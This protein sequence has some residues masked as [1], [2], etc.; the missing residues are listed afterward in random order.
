MSDDI[1]WIKD[2][3]EIGAVAAAYAHAADAISR[4]DVEEGR[5]LIKTCFAE[6]AVFDAFMPNQDLSTPPAFS[7]HGP[8]AWVDAG[9]K[10]FAAM[11]YKATQHHMG[12]IQ[13][14]VDGDTATME[15]CLTGPHIIDSD[16]AIDFI[17][18]TYTD[19]LART[20]E[21]W[22]IKHRRLRSTG[23][24][25][26]ESPAREKAAASF[27]EMSPPKTEEGAA[28][29]AT[30]HPSPRAA[31][32]GGGVEESSLNDRKEIE[33]LATAYASA[34]DA[35]TRGDVEEARQILKA[36]FTDKTLFESYLPSSD[37][38]GPPDWRVV[39]P[40]AWIEAVAAVRYTDAQHHVGNVLIDVRGDTAAMWSCMTA[41]LI[42]ERERSIDLFTGSYTDRLER[43]PSGFRI[44]HRRVLGTSFLRLTSPPSGALERPIEAAAVRE[45]KGQAPLAVDPRPADDP[46]ALRA[47]M[48]IEAVAVAYAYAADALGRGDVEQGR[49]IIK[50]CFTDDAVFEAFGPGADPGAPPLFSTTGPD[51]W[52]DRVYAGLRDAGCTVTQHHIGNIEVHRRGDAAT[53]RCCLTATHGTGSSSIGLST[54]SYSDDMVRTAEGWRI[55]RRRLQIKSGLHLQ[56]SI[57][58]AAEAAFDTITRA[59]PQPPPDD[60]L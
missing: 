39:G 7:F 45:P 6:D 29:A 32:A 52:V 42:R 60:P 59:I 24:L 8:D 40:D 57:R 10:T 27:A 47:Q 30:P 20:P 3:I 15:C 16:R 26:L 4:G 19:R 49:A 23:L 38:S 34:A 18:G 13:V 28:A 22:R 1:R 41:T 37:R 2:Q 43:T 54:G 11:S 48:E 58:D 55:A 44:L 51:A 36:C 35:A 12:N 46:S 14:R 9:L 50:D 31:R 33:A 17:T 5:A 25:R 21:G 53:M 56:S